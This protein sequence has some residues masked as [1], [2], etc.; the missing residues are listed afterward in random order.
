MP[1]N[2]DLAGFWDM[3]HIQVIP[4]TFSLTSS[5]LLLSLS[6]SPPTLLLSYFTFSLQSNHHYLKKFTSLI[7][8]NFSSLIIFFYISIMTTNSQVEQIHS[9]FQGL[10]E[11][12]LANWVVKVIFSSTSL[13]PSVP[14]FPPP[15]PPFSIL[16]WLFLPSQAE[17]KNCNSNVH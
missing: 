6:S 8:I 13:P 1:T 9:R 2:M 17:G 14:P 15:S 5:T 12:K 11:L 16:P 4:S 7:L 3:V 10:T